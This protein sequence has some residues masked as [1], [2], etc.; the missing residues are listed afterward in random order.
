MSG[1]SSVFA[2]LRCNLSKTCFCLY[3]T[4]FQLEK[5]LD[6][7]GFKFWNSKSYD[8]KVNENKNASV[9]TILLKINDFP[10]FIWKYAFILYLAWKEREIEGER[11]SLIFSFQNF[12]KEV[13]SFHFFREKHFFWNVN[14]TNNSFN[15]FD[16]HLIYRIKM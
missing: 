5:K 16:S 4:Q 2:C 6:Y 13:E 3:W 11:E 12:A 10:F 1:M 9:F 8:G 7:C 14:A 15:K